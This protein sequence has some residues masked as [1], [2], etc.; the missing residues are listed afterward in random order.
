MI[1]TLLEPSIALAVGPLPGRNTAWPWR[2]HHGPDRL[3]H[4]PGVQAA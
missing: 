1:T 3:S 2:L 4:S